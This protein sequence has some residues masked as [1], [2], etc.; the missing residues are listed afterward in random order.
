MGGGYGQVSPDAPSSPRFS[1]APVWVHHGLQSFGNIHLWRHRSSTGRRA[2][3]APPWSTTFPS[4]SDLGV[5][6]AVSHSFSSLLFSLFSIFTEVPPFWLRGS[7]GSCGESVGAGWNRLEPAVP[8]RGAGGGGPAAPPCCQ[9][10]TR[11]PNTSRGRT[12]LTCLTK[13]IETQEG[14]TRTRTQVSFFL[15]ENLHREMAKTHIFH[16]RC[17]VSLRFQL[18]KNYIHC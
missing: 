14:T 12:F 15:T 11:K 1:S 16:S 9:R 3:L 8:S 18:P 17:R 4:F 2:I 5:R 13:K 6:T 7:A 10:L